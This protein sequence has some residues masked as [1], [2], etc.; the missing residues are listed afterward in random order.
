M[1][2]YSKIEV[3]ENY[4]CKVCGAHGVR[5]YREYNTFSDYITLRCTHCSLE[6]QKKSE[7]DSESGHTIGWLVAAVPTE[8]NKTFWGFTSLP[9]PGVEWWNKL[10]TAIG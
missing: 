2:D 7:P 5:L 10:P 9:Q 8:D 1:L 4:A 3:P 6:N